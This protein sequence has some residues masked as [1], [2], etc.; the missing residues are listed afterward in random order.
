MDLVMRWHA[1]EDFA[2]AGDAAPGVLEVA[3][4]QLFHRDAQRL[5]HAQRFEV[6]QQRALEEHGVAVDDAA[7]A[8]Q[9]AALDLDVVA[10]PEFRR[11]AEAFQS[12]RGGGA[13][14]CGD[15][16]EVGSEPASLEHQLPAGLSF[17]QV[18]AAAAGDAPPD[19]D[20]VGRAVL[21]PHLVAEHLVQADESAGAKAQEAD[22]LR[23]APCVA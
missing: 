16:G 12:R 15:R 20:A 3:P 7:S 10:G 5:D 9:L 23:A 2:Q 1:A 22:G 6:H 4:R 11:H 18:Q 13:D 21:E 19:L 17:V 14:A 8:A